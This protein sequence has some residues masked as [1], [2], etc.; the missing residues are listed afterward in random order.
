MSSSVAI[1]FPGQGSQRQGM[2]D[3]LPNER[4]AAGLAVYAEELSGLPLR[5]IAAAGEAGPLAD[6]RA[7]QP[8]LFIADVS[9]GLALVDAG[10]IPAGLAGHSLGELAA[11]AVAGVFHPR[12]GVELVVERSRLMADA[13]AATPG[14]MIAVLGMDGPAVT[15]AI[16]GLPDVWVANDN[17]P[18]QV[19]ISGLRPALESASAALDAA[20]AR[21]L[22]A[23]SVAGPFHSPLMAPAADAFDKVLAD[24]PFSDA[25][26]PVWQNVHPEP[27]TSGSALRSRLSSQITSPVRWTETMRSLAASGVRT[28][29]EAGPGKVLAGL[30]GRVEPLR[31]V[32]ADDRGVTGVLEEVASS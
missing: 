21:K 25:S 22:I 8:M 4:L 13:A 30:A 11:L 5:E 29:V 9:W 15:T 31:A 28:L 1:V 23:L 12:T 3:S 26:V 17:A 2:L 18:G 14:G 24:V 16:E 10:L 19:V 6:T 27:E 32:T 7:A 20:G